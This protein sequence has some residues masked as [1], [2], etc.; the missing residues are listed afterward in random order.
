MR[1]LLCLLLFPTLSLAQPIVKD[2]ALMQ[3]IISYAKENSVNTKQVDWDE[4]IPRAEAL[5]ADSGFIVASQLILRELGDYHGRIWYNQ[6]PY[7]GLTKNISSSSM[8]VDEQSMELY[9][10]STAK[11]TSQL[12]GEDIGYIQVPGIGMSPNDGERAHEINDMVMELEQNNDIDG[13]IL[14][15]RMNGGGTMFPMLCGLQSFLGD[16]AFG[17][18]I[19]L[20]N[21]F[22][23]EW[24]IVDNELYIDTFMMSGYGIERVQNLSEKPVVVL[25]SSLTAS[26]GEVVAI[27]FK[28][29]PNTT[30]IGEPTSGY[31]TTVSWRDMGNDIYFQLTESWYADR[32]EHIYKGDP[33]LPDIPMEGGCALRDLENDTW[34]LRALEIL[35]P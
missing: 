8:A 9:R 18:F 30:F 26:S 31:T 33:V 21:D 28:D 23:Q 29:R 15:L 13:W 20:E 35:A 24:K 3:E 25:I 11:V 32:N 2:K 10:W 17:S 27:A 34:V 12:I 1:L 19:D 22:K 6:M 4:L 14:D 5:H 7:N 16:E